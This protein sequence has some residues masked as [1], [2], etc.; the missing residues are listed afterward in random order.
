MRKL[1]KGPY[2]DRDELNRILSLLD[3]DVRSIVASAI[4][5]IPAQPQAPVV[6]QQGTINTGMLGP[7]IYAYISAAIAAATPVEDQWRFVC[8]CDVGLCDVG[9]SA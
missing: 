6:I 8:L 1:T 4:A 7:D 5:A 9:L 2:A 3:G